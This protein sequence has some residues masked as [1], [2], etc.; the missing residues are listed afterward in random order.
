MDTPPRPRNPIAHT[1]NNGG[2]YH[3]LAEHLT[4]VANLA[5][6]FAGKFD[7]AEYG[8]AAGQWHDLGKYH[9]EF[10][11]YLF[12]AHAGKRRRSIDHKAAGVTVAA[13]YC[14]FLAGPLQG[15]HGGLRNVSELKGW[16]REMGERGRVPL[17]LDLAREALGRFEPDS[18][19]PLPESITTRHQVEFLVRML[20]SA[21]VDA[22]FLDTE[23]HFQGEQARRR[24]GYPAI[25]TLWDELQRDQERL[26]GQS[27]DPV[28]SVRHRVY[29]DCLVA[30]EQPPGFFRLTVPTG[31]GKTR[32]GLAFALR[33][34]E[35]YDLDRVIVAVP[36][37]SITDQTAATYR[38]I[39]SDPRS[40]LEHHS[41]AEWQSAGEEGSPEE[42]WARLAA[43]NWDAPLIVTTTV[44]LFESLFAR[45]TSRCRKLHNIARSVIILDEA[46]TLPETLLTPTLDVLSELVRAYSATV[47]LSTATQPAF[48]QR[49]GF[50]GLPDLREIVT[51]PES[52]FAALRRVEYEWDDDPKSWDEIADLMRE[53]RQAMTIVNTRADALELMEALSDDDPL[54][55]STLLCGAHRRD[56]LDEVKRR[57]DAN[58][59][60][61]LVATQVVEA[62]VDIDFPFVLR[63]LGPLDR[64]VQAAGRCNREGKL[65]RGRVI[66]F[67]TE[68]GRTPP[69]AYSTG[70]G[71]AEMLL[72][73]T[74]INLH[75]PELYQ[76][77]FKG[78]YQ[79]VNL[80]NKQIQD[81]R[82]HY[83]FEEV[84][85]RYR[86]IADDGLPVVVPYER[87]LPD[88][89][90]LDRAL[91]D[92]QDKRG[93]PR[94]LWRKLQPFLLN[95]RRWDLEQLERQALVVP[96]TESLYRWTGKYDKDLGIGRRLPNP[97]SLVVG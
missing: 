19:L 7:A 46:Q 51:D 96:V 28:N 12:D 22:D 87:T 24:G 29:K 34:A 14:Q 91:G 53:Q 65:E 77:Y 58:E 61:L 59:P 33:H 40:V 11:Q 70:T 39:F 95:I 25:G 23:A 43:E 69:G 94:D 17:A 57:L 62:G 90:V 20:F 26:T 56:V 1:P 15:H 68:E 18:S 73:E 41:G 35:M 49:E 42:T 63:A 50:G 38:E 37:L 83:N 67:R 89:T 79:R 55:L 80:D 47:V 54:H 82:Q 93:N 74:G 44:Q 76:R 48:D 92:L 72:A 5:R 32:S 30:A 3:D 10:Q 97:E 52:H 9:P 78:L 86:Y 31:G 84:A 16:L 64:I 27:D 2:D 36:Y 45:S 85:R 71:V 21:L 60:C 6:E 75:A 66:I 4:E 8:D 88:G 81:Q 13:E